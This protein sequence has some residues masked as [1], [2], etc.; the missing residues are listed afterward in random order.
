M[1]AYLYRM[2]TGIA[3][4]VSRPQDLTIEPVLIN[5][6]NPF[7][8]Y[9]LAG[10]FSGNFFVPL[11][12]NDTAD[13]IVGI[14]V[15]PFPT[16]STPDKVRQI[17]TSNNFAGDALKRGYMSVNIGATAAGVTKGAPVYIRIADATDASPLGSVLATAIADTTVVLPN[18]YFT[19]AGDA[20]GNTEISYKI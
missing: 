20:A 17:G 19:G 12:E 8:Q 11:D 3:G 14:F 6:A 7:S 18:A 2:P 10:K 9:G 1:T 16:T 4:A 13:K 15:R 5:T